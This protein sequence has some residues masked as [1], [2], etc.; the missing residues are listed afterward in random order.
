[1]APGALCLQ[2]SPLS[3]GGAI[4]VLNVVAVLPGEHVF[5]MCVGGIIGEGHDFCPRPDILQF[6]QHHR[7]NTNSMLWKFVPA[8]IPI[9]A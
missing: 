9:E 5:A 6:V 2:I 4:V 8:T 1:M 3:Y 7:D